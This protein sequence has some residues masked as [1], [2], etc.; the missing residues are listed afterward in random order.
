MGD[1]DKPRGDNGA[2]LRRTV[3]VALAALMVTGCGVFTAPAQPTAGD[4]TDIV[5]ALV[6]RNMTITDQVAGDP[7]CGAQISSPLYSNAVRYDVR[8]AGDPNSYAVYVFGWKSQATFDADKVE[9]DVC[10]QAE[11]QST[12]APVTT[13]EH[14]PW[15]AFGPAWPTGLSDAVD[16]AL[17]EAGGIPAPQEPE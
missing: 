15:R 1:P 17:K 9:F 10:V 3:A 8:P 16:A 6:R 2:V 13:V 4:L 12:I 11:E 7:G 5:S 14:L